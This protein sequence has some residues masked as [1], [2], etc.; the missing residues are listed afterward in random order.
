M[1]SENECT[2]KV[3]S[4]NEVT[5][6]VYSE[7]EV[8]KK[9]NSENECTKK[10]IVS[11]KECTKKIIDSEN[12]YINICSF[13]NR[14]QNKHM[15]SFVHQKQQNSKKIIPHLRSCTKFPVVNPLLHI[16]HYSIRLAKIL[17]LK[18]EGVIEKIS[19]ECRVYES[20]DDSSLS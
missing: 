5:K 9:V 15:F 1:N 12:E 3:N 8:T 7:N 19:Y 10:I 13:S 20:V 18:L 16:G 11:E 6:K 14:A 2:K 4:E 17:I